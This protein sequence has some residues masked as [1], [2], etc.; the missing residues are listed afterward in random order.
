M[1]TSCHYKGSLEMAVR[2]VGG[3]C[4]MATNLQGHEPGS[5]GTSTSEDSRQRRLS[6]CCSELQCCV[7]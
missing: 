2:R 4:E 6:A 3:W 1:K 7:N 5:R